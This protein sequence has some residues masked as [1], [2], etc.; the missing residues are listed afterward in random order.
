MSSF[1]F[2]GGLYTLTGNGQCTMLLSKPYCFISPQVFVGH[3]LCLLCY[4][5][6]MNAHTLNLC[7]TPSLVVLL[8]DLLK[9]QQPPPTCYLPLSLCCQCFWHVYLREYCKNAWTPNIRDM[10]SLLSFVVDGLKLHQPPCTWFLSH[11]LLLLTLTPNV[12]HF[13]SIIIHFLKM[14]AFTTH[15]S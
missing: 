1:L 6:K 3:Y 4:F 2:V 15:S 9:L 10:H 11:A 8:V 7:D 14:M 5:S 13:T 12:R